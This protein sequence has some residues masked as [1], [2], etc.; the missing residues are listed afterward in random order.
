MLLAGD[1]NIT[2]GFLP[3]RGMLE[4]TTNQIAGFTEELHER[5]GNVLMADGSVWQ[6]SSARLRSE[7]I[8]NTGVATNR[9]VLP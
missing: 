5:Q 3:R 2:N 8:R 7:I 9:I 6:V 4:L 1:R